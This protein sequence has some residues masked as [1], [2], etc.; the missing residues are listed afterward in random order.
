MSEPTL[1]AADWATTRGEKW[2]AQL[3]GMEA[4]LAPVD[5]PLSAALRLD[6]PYR[7]ADIG[8][9]GGGATRAIA[10]RAPEGSIVHGFDISPVLIETAR[11]R[12]VGAE[13]QVA[14][15]AAAAPLGPVYDRLTSRFGIMFFDDP[16]A[17]FANLSRWLAPGGRFAFAVWGPPSAN[18]WMKVVKDTVA[19]IIEVPAVDPEAPGPF[20][21]ADVSKLEAL[22]S[23][24]GFREVEVQG[25]HG[26]LPIGGGL[27]AEEATDFALES[28][29]SLADWL[30]TAEDRDA[31]TKARRILLERFSERLVDGIVQMDAAVHIVVGTA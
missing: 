24:A 17:A 11:S 19:E 13:F 22:L 4:M 8:C 28:F 30:K 14:D 16:S 2:L 18:P 20:R 21:Y 6:A 23:S 27:P 9:G 1:A 3:D 5:E 15:A 31:L 29:S 25:W 10:N 7:I 26:K 12:V